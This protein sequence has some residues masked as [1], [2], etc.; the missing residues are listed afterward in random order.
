[1]LGRDLAD[2]RDEIGEGGRRSANASPGVLRSLELSAPR[3]SREHNPALAIAGGAAVL[4]LAGMVVGEAVWAP[5]LDVAPQIGT[6]AL[7]AWLLLL[8]R[9]VARGAPAG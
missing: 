3:G 7:V 1:M 9:A 5:A 6:P 4:G 2:L 8:P